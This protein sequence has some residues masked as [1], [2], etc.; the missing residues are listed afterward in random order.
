GSS[1]SALRRRHLLA[2]D[3][4]PRTLTRARVRV[5]A[6]AAHREVL[7]VPQ[8]AIAPEVDEALD[9]LRRLAAQIALDLEVRVDLAADAIHLV[10]GQIVG[11]ATRVDLGASA[12]AERRGATDPVD[13]RERDLHALVAR[14][15]DAGDSCHRTLLARSA[16]PLLVARV[17]AHDPDDAL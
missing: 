16:L 4:L 11:L 10:V 1:R 6:L 3:G 17:L 15:I 5:R 9:V 7:A 13:V 12:D 8:A 2:R 14:Q